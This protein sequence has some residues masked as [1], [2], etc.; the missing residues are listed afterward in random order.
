[1]RLLT[2]MK[3]GRTL[4]TLAPEMTTPDRIAALVQ[5]GA[6]VAAGH[7]DADYATSRAALDAGVT[8]FTHLFNAMSPLASREPGVVGAALENVSAWAGIIVDGHHVDPV[9]L[10][11][12]LRCRPAD[13]FMLVTDAMPS[14]NAPH[15]GDG[16]EH[17]YLQGRR[18]SVKDGACLDERGVLAGSDLDMAA[19]VRNTRDLLGLDL[20][21]AV[22]MASAAPAAFLGLER[23]RGQI[24]PGYAADLLILN[25]DLAVVESWIDGVPAPTP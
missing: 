8:G 2:R 19:A 11:L 22:M 3:T 14:V 12:A 10:K 20:A 13:R 15:L 23:Q 17:F 7:T 25:N 6:V 4:I 18:I 24:A 1:M 9:V 16:D 5:G 21:T